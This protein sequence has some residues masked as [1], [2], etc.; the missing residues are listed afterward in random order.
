MDSLMG[1]ART[2]F[3][4]GDSL[5]EILPD[6]RAE[7]LRLHETIEEVARHLEISTPFHAITP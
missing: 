7:N 6:F 4:G 5:Q 2:F 3:I 1:Y